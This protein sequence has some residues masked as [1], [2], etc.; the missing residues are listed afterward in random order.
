MKLTTLHE[1]ELFLDNDKQEKPFFKDSSKFFRSQDLN[2]DGGMLVAIMERLSSSSKQA[3]TVVG[4]D[5]IRLLKAITCLKGLDGHGYNIYEIAFLGASDDKWTVRFGNFCQ[6][7][8]TFS[9]T[10]M[11][12]MTVVSTVIISWLEF[13]HFFDYEKKGI[14]HN[15]HVQIWMISIASM[16]YYWNLIGISWT[17]CTTFNTTV[18]TLCPVLQRQVPFFWSEDDISKRALYCFT[19]NQYRY[20]CLRL[21]ELQNIIMAIFLWQLNF[22]FIL[23]SGSPNDAILNSVATG[24]ILEIDDAVR[25]F[26]K[27]SS[28]IRTALSNYLYLDWDNDE[29]GD[30]L[31]GIVDKFLETPSAGGVTVRAVP[32]NS[33]DFHPDGVCVFR[34][35]GKVL[36][37]IQHRN[38]ALSEVTY[39]ISGDKSKCDDFLE[40]L[41]QLDC[42]EEEEEGHQEK[43]DEEEEA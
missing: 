6:L 19:E 30:R 22:W 23:A 42:V 29:C 34:L 35:K 31:I 11:F 36:T 39:S 43:L 17:S 32:T 4:R 41:K 21:N 38:G 16:A 37:V 12:S 5:P 20:W 15:E 3:R 10:I 26:S 7:F 27:G 1:T 18:K 2:E 13:N 24:F 14:T 9:V 25:G 28:S 33:I 8:A 40:D